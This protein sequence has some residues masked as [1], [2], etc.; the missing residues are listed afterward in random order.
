MVCFW[1][2]GPDLAPSNPSPQQIGTVVIQTTWHSL[3]HID[4][5]PAPSGS[6]AGPKG[7]ITPAFRL[8]WSAPIMRHVSR[9]GRRPW[10]TW[11]AWRTT[12][13]ISGDHR[14]KYY[15]R[16]GGAQSPTQTLPV[17]RRKR[18]DFGETE[19]SAN[20]TSSALWG[21]VWLSNSLFILQPQGTSWD[22]RWLAVLVVGVPTVISLALFW[23]L[24]SS[25]IGGVAARVRARRSWPP[26]NAGGLFSPR[27]AVG[28]GA[29]CSE[30]VD[31]ENKTRFA[32][33]TFTYTSQAAPGS[34]RM[35]GP[36]SWVTRDQR[37]SAEIWIG[38]EKPPCAFSLLSVLLRAFSCRSPSSILP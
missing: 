4:D 24:R 36:V 8:K 12:R 11:R 16:A 1:K 26:A 28:V 32:L 18:F 13:I 9:N 35:N 37:T 20:V 29:A 10:P 17:E 19:L 38:R 30:I 6:V 25:C 33:L 7:R 34:A 21:T 2:H 27:G 23:H 31:R 15:V 3:Q 14:G 5:D 22:G